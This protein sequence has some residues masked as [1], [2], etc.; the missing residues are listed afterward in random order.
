[1]E[2]SSN[3][4][5]GTISYI[6]TQNLFANWLNYIEKTILFKMPNIDHKILIRERDACEFIKIINEIMHGLINKFQVNDVRL[7][8]IKNW[9]DHK[10]LN[11]S[12]KSVVQ[13]HGGAV[14]SDSALYNEWREKVTVPPFNPNRVM[15]ET[16]FRIQPTVNKLFEE[17]L[18]KT[19]P[20][21]DNIH[22]PISKYTKNGLFI[23]YSS[24]TE[25]N[26]KG[27]LMIYRVQRDIVSTFYASFDNNNGWKIRRTKNIRLGELT[28]YRIE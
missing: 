14:V 16:F 25:L 10:W 19:K 24:D 21:N 22:N 6:Y 1:M 15:S 9:F 23:W 2:N 17:R 20:S 18:H 4:F 7:V 28:C 8:R 5:L 11:Y 3:S 27:S 12:G 26:Q 13:F